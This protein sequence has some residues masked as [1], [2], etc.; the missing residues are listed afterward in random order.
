M[1]R[2]LYGRGRRVSLVLAWAVALV[3]GMGVAQPGSAQSGLARFLPAAVSVE[4]QDSSGNILR[5]VNGTL[6]QEGVIVPL[7]SLSGAAKAQIKSRDGSV[8][9]TETYSTSHQGIGIVILKL[10]QV[11]DYALTY[12]T[13]GAFQ[14]EGKATILLGPDSPTDSTGTILHYS[15]ALR[16]GTDFV[17]ITPGAP[18]AAPVIDR[19]GRFLGV[20]GDISTP[21]YPAGYMVPMVSIRAVASAQGFSPISGLAGASAPLYESAASAI[22][23]TF[24]GASILTAKRPEDARTL[25]AQAIKADPELSDAHF[26]LGRALF[27]LEQWDQAAEEFQEATRIDS[28]YHMAWHLAGAAYNQGA[29]YLD[30]EKMYMK[31]LE[32]KPT[33]ADTYCNLGGA[34]F[35]QHRN[36]KAIEAFR[37]SIDLDPRY[38]FG[39]AYSNLALTYNAMGQRAEAEKVYQELQKVYPESA[40]RLRQS[41]DGN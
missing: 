10:P 39:L 15:F 38:Q 11:P 6:V 35:N 9:N 37:K 25:L 21:G 34:Y 3:A 5:S 41:L 33:A 32:V 30:A 13:N 26:W 19:T 20:A 22:G 8:W 40:A 7:T 31:A 23:M 28:N 36:D 1:L 14:P 16:D 17:S 18:G 4:I 29:R 12:P 27:V 24:R 2:K